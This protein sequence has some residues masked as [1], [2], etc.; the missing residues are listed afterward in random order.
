MDIYQHKTGI[1]FF[2]AFL[3][4][5]VV[6]GTLWYTDYLAKKLV[7]RENKLIHL[8]AKALENTAK[9]IGTDHDISFMMEEII[10]ANVS[11][12]VI[13]ADEKGNPI[14]DKNVEY[15]EGIK[16]EDKTQL[17]KK[18]IAIMAEQH[19]P[20][21]VEFYG[22]VN[23]IYYK[24]SSLLTMLRYYPY[25]Q[26]GAI[27][28]LIIVG[29]AAFSYSRK[30]EQNRVWVGLAK[31]TAHQLGTPLSSLMAISEYMKE[32]ELIK[33]N[34]MVM[35]LAK[36]VERLEVITQRFA[37]IGLDGKL[38]ALTVGEMVKPQ[39][40][41]LQART[42][43]KIQFHFQDDSNHAKAFINAAL[44]G[45]VIENIC[46]NAI[47]AMEGKGTLTVTMSANEQQVWM[48][49]TDTGKGMNKKTIKSIFKPGF[50]TKKRGWGLG[51]TLVKR[52]MEE[53][54]NGK[55]VVLKS[56][57]NAGTTFRLT[58]ERV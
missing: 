53:Y 7:V 56:E 46:K 17:L 5:V 30:S 50:T 28:L 11:I 4:L 34:P 18:E 47:D 54:H 37:Q 10:Q 45:W 9:N 21:K 57:P 39:L 49:I 24:N 8:Y 44:M 14:S 48:D 31:E 42:S 52:I 58:W 19:E 23:Y 33:N 51:L 29:Y 2:M 32:D 1:K 12:P 13:L 43:S 40:D 20:I 41:Y 26:L 36:D 38:E 25:V 27:I 16:E 3:G 15:P 22:I 6:L 55:V 35:E